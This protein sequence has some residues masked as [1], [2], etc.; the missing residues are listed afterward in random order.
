MFLP[1][2]LCHGGTQK[3][4]EQV[5]EL[6]TC[7][8]PTVL[9]NHRYDQCIS[10]FHSFKHINLQNRHWN[11]SYESNLNKI[12][13]S[14]PTSP[15]IR[16][17]LMVSSDKFSCNGPGKS[18][19]GQPNRMLATLVSDLEGFIHDDGGSSSGHGHITRHLNFAALNQIPKSILYTQ[20]FC[21]YTFRCENKSS[22]PFCCESLPS[23][24]S[25]NFALRTW[26]FA[27]FLAQW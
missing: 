9:T 26:R 21:N 22:L 8:E 16:C 4:V 1:K 23:W 20:Q 2:N 17:L 18:S 27:R 19:T 12:Q 14:I 10:G 11:S 24:S 5:S 15:Q 7:K 13:L 25:N 6:H 3:E